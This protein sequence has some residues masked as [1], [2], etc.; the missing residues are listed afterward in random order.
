[1]Y[2]PIAH[3]GL[4]PAMPNSETDAE[5]RCSGRSRLHQAAPPENTQNHHAEMLHRDRQVGKLRDDD[6][7]GDDGQSRGPQT[8]WVLQDGRL[9]G[10][11]GEQQED[12]DA[13]AG[14]T[15]VPDQLPA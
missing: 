12:C 3:D 13:C 7:E 10:R 1:V 9:P 6:I 11:Q 4:R 2:S 8:S 5:S 15:P 14:P